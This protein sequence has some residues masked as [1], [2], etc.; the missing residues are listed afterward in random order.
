TALTQ[1]LL[2]FARRQELKPQA[3]DFLRLLENVEDLLAK[4]VG[5]SIEIRKSIPADL[6]PLLVESNQ[7]ELALLN[8]FVNARD[9]LE[10]GGAVT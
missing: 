3:V 1:R 10:S 8:L 9:A 7:L 4:A 5:P 2:A 6:A